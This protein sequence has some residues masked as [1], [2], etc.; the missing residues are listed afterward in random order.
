[1]NPLSAINDDKII[2]YSEVKGVGVKEHNIV[3]ECKNRI[4]NAVACVYINEMPLQ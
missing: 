2:T 1:M 4:H 3:Y